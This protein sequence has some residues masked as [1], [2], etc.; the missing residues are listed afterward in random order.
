MYTHELGAFSGDCGK[1]WRW[2]VRGN[3]ASVVEAAV[4]LE[5]GIS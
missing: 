1:Y 2:R 4:D 5:L 3:T